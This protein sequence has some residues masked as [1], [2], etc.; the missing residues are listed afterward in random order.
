MYILGVSRPINL[1]CSER[2]RERERERERGEGGREIEIER[3]ID[4][5]C[6]VQYVLF[7]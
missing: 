3:E 4:D 1:L 6:I 2:K 5:L 7:M